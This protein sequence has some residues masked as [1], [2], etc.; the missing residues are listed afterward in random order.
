MKLTKDCSGRLPVLG[1]TAVARYAGNKPELAAWT[2][3][4][5]ARRT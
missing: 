2:N 3:S 5:L 1:A 4:L